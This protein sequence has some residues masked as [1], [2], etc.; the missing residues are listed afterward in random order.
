MVIQMVEKKASQWVAR[1]DV[2]WVVH[3]DSWRAGRWV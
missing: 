1:R 2:Q 3:W